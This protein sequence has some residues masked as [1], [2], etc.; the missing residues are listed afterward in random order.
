MRTVKI[1][2]K[3]RRCWHAWRKL[4]R[5]Q[6]YL[7][8][9]LDE[10]VRYEPYES[11][12]GVDTHEESRRRN[13]TSQRTT[14]WWTRTVR[15][16]RKWGG[17]DTQKNARV[18][19]TLQ[20]TPPDERTVRFYESG[21]GVDTHE[22]SQ[23]ETNVTTYTT[24]MNAYGTNSTKAEEVLT[25]MKKVGVKPDV[26]TYNTLMNAYGTN[27]ES[28][29]VL[30]RMEKAR[31]KP[32]SQRTTLDE[33]VRY[34]F[35]ESGGV[36]TRMKKA[37]VKPNVTTYATLMNAFGTNPTK[38]EEVL[39]RMKKAGVKPDVTT[40]H[41]D[42]RTVRILRKRRC[43]VKKAG[44]KPTLL[45]TP[46]WWTRTVRT[47]ESGGCV[48]TYEE[49]RETNVATYSTLMNAYGTNPKKAEVVTH[50]EG[51]SETKR[52]NPN[53]LMNAYGKSHE[54]GGGVCKYEKARKPDALRT[55]LWW[56]RTVWILRKR[57]RC[58]H[59]WRKP[60]ETR[61]YNVHHSDERVRYESTKAEEVLTRM[62]KAGVKPDVTTY[63]TLMNAY[64][65]NPTKAND[66]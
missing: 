63:N 42:E 61:R 49:S 21:G 2:R 6:T 53:T 33:R 24:L 32:T 17:V 22:E 50:E 19:Q 30:T 55:T 52:Y 44:E 5:N 51:R 13:Q 57:R 64:C 1:L 41:S 59:T 66:A 27:S 10:R 62:K 15:T 20:R 7:R 29:E 40:Q 54:S 45:R 36:V 4:E 60:S 25:R 48:D 39:T 11:G 56:T 31:V 8:T 26:F 65:T 37:G 18:N 9:T 58:W 3:W 47:W 46:L 28:E 23:S 38:A 35:Y 43:Y 12:G 16:L 34:E 14:L